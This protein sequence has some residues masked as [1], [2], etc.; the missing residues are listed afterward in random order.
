M[1]KL[2]LLNGLKYT[3]EKLQ[4]RRAYTEKK[5]MKG[6]PTVSHG[7]QNLTNLFSNAVI[8]TSPQGGVGR[9]VVTAGGRALH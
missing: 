6:P 8:I 9:G 1:K 4:I 2:T 3:T 7:I 5:Y